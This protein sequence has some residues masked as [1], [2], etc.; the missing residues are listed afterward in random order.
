MKRDL[1]DSTAQLWL[2]RRIHTNHEATVTRAGWAGEEMEEEGFI[3]S[4][5][6]TQDVSGRATSQPPPL[7][8]RVLMLPALFMPLL[9][10]QAVLGGTAALL[11]LY[12]TT[13][14]F[15]DQTKGCQLSTRS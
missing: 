7:H 4:P 11:I 1:T 5:Q 12:I 10:S 15:G 8:P 13:F 9:D 3:S 2:L 6:V 14:L